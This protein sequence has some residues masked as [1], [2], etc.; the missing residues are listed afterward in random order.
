MTASAEIRDPL[1]GTRIDDRYLVRGVIGRGGMGVVYEGVHERLGRPVAIKVL[2][3][4]IAGDR[5]AVERFLREARTA[6]LLTH[7][8]IVDVS[9]LGALPDGRP[10]LVMAMLQGT[11]LCSLLQQQGPQTPRRAAE[12]LRGA[13]SALDLI[14]AKGFVHRD[15]K[16]E[17]LMH[18]VREDGSEAVLLLDFG[19]V[20]LISP[21]MQRLTANGVVFGTPAYLSPEAIKGAPPHPLSDIYALATVCFE[22][23]TGRPPF[24]N[25]NPLL[26][27]QMKLAQ[28][29]PSL[30]TCA[31]YDFPPAIEA[32]I[33]R[34]LTRD[35]E[36]RY[37]TAG[38]MIA[39]LD[40]AVQQHASMALPVNHNGLDRHARERLKSGTSMLEFSSVAPE[41]TTLQSEPP[42][43]GLAAR[44]RQ[45][46]I[47]GATAAAVLLLCVLAWW[48]GTRGSPP[49][50]TAA[51]AP[52][53][54]APQPAAPPPVA[55]APSVSAL[56][57][58]VAAPEPPAPHAEV[59]TAPRAHAS[60]PSAQPAARAPRTTTLAPAPEPPR[61][62]PAA[63][64]PP[65]VAP[66]PPAVTGPSASELVSRAQKELVEGH[67]AAS[68]DLYARATQL[69]PKNAAAYRGLGL[70][71]ERLGR[72]KEAI[73]AL[74]QAMQLA[75]TSPTNGALQDRLRRLQDE[76]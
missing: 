58:S 54:K 24:E 42:D 32:A 76:P 28:E 37:K 14:H 23:I 66:P 18:V 20:G 50:P 21:E 11:D 36:K 17:N 52:A 73:R 43:V 75:P 56:Q 38:A 8:N 65:H 63:P 64:E 62:A 72:R 13:A 12:L 67:I 61:V 19:I 46:V 35:P 34:G 16:P 49:P 70:A 47:G 69:D 31:G 10:Y 22:L 55:S 51:A 40:A 33:A 74:K 1:V 39:A 60:R 25:D 26:L 4:G 30:G 68:A 53:A 5:T 15:V 71:Y 45:R 6:S 9:D 29:A 44:R 41:A 57:P 27:M 3:P 48:L 59:S 2:G 7:G